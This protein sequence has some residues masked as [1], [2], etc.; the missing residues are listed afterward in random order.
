M[1]RDCFPR[2]RKLI[3]PINFAVKR[4]VR[5][6]RL[7][8]LVLALGLV[9][10]ACGDDGESASDAANP[11]DDP[12]AEGERTGTLRLGYFAN[13][14]H[15]PAVIGEEEGIFAGALGDGVEIEYSY[16]N[17]GTEAIEALFAGA[18]D[19]SFIGPN[20]ALNGFA[21]SD[22]EALRIVSGVTSGGASLVVRDGINAPEDLADT[23]LASPSL[24]NTQ[25]VAM[26]AWLAEQGYETE[27]TGAGDVEISPQDNADTLTAF[28]AGSIDGAWVPEP[29]ATRLV[30]EGDG[31][32]LVDERDIWPDS[33]FVTTHLMVGTDYLDENP[34][35]VQGLI[36]GLLE[37]IDVANGDAA[38]AQA[39]TN[40]GIERITTQALADETIASAWDKMTF[41]P[42]P[43][44]SSLEES[45]NDAVAAGLLDEV[46][47][48][49]IHD[50]TILNELLAE[51]GE[52]EVEGL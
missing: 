29:W 27:Q 9:A 28:V 13:V 37:A 1:L 32:V 11:A 5:R 46:D 42:D 24:G 10:A 39:I 38:E 22:G 43:V 7:V 47:L 18:I 15:A 31:H 40:A 45:K 19:A 14:T 33:E 23:R 51:R 17:S 52:T 2:C 41:T 34:E 30:L 44:A 12:S 21:Q 6:F 26:R 49:G 20:P 35:I 50:L 8:A 48:T 36:E 3:M 25:D 16:F 4:P